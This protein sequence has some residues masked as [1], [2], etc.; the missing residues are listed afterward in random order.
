MRPW[1]YQNKDM[2]R[3]LVPGYGAAMV[4][5]R[6]RRLS[7]HN[8]VKEDSKDSFVCFCCWFVVGASSGAHVAYTKSKSHI[9]CSSW[10]G[11]M[12]VCV[13]VCRTI[14]VCRLWLHKSPAWHVLHWGGS[15]ES[16][17]TCKVQL[18]ENA[19]TKK[20][21]TKADKDID[22][23]ERHLKSAHPTTFTS[24]SPGSCCSTPLGGGGDVLPVPFLLLLA[25]SSAFSLLLSVCVFFY[26][27]AS[28]MTLRRNCGVRAKFKFSIVATLI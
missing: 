19:T 4:M 27:R 8:G 14:D 9:L 21:E 6:W 28:L 3:K 2:K 24:L 25:S 10:C 11:M 22:N 26:L 17:Q 1:G 20:R 12:C 23:D 7:R 15:R 16:S 18:K 13:R 5:R